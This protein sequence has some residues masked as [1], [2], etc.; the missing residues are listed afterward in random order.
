[1]ST[2]ERDILICLTIIKFLINFFFNQS[3]LQSIYS[4]LLHN[5]FVFS[6]VKNYMTNIFS[7]NS[8]FYFN[9]SCPLLCLMLLYLKATFY[10]FNNVTV[11][12]CGIVLIASFPVLKFS[13]FHYYFKN[14]FYRRHARQIFLKKITVHESQSFNAKSHFIHT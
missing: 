4:K 14:V 6:D 1:M 9:K 10:C 12:Y 3:Y 8:I 7:V 2:S 5:K 11:T 13:L